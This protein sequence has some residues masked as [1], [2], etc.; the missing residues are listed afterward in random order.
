MNNYSPI[1]LKNHAKAWLE[2]YKLGTEEPG[3]GE[4]RQASISSFFFGLEFYLKAYLASMND[5]FQDGEKLKKL[6]HNFSAIFCEIV[7]VG[8]LELSILIKETLVNFNLFEVDVIE[9]RYPSVGSC[10]IYDENFYNGTHG[11]D[12]LFN[13]LDKIFLDNYA[14]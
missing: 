7:K 9:L 13:K 6:G 3:N 8:D 10:A 2:L 4:L 11:C 1:Q 14:F 5:A 12:N